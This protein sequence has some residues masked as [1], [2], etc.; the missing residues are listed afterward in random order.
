MGRGRGESVWDRVE[1]PEARLRVIIV[2]A[3]PC[4]HTI[5][6]ATNDLKESHGSLPMPRNFDPGA[7]DGGSAHLRSSFCAQ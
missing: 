3:I 1:K 6:S 7:D 4:H 5:L 2:I